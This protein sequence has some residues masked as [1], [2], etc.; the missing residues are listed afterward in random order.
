MKFTIV[1]PIYNTQ[2]YLPRLLDCLIRQT[3]KDIE[4]I[5]VDDGSTD[6]SGKICD[7][8]ALK[9]ERIKVIHKENEK[10]AE[11]RNE[12][13]RRASGDYIVF[14]DSDDYIDLNSCRVF[15]EAIIKQEEIDIL[16]SNA[17]SLNKE[18]RYKRF[19]SSEKPMS[20]CDFIKTQ[21]KAGVYNIG[22]YYFICKTS[23]L[24]GNSLYFMRNNI[25]EDFLWA[26][27]CCLLAKTMR[28]IDFAHY[29]YY[30][31]EGSISAMRDKSKHLSDFILCC[32]EIEKLLINTKD[33]ELKRIIADRNI[34]FYIRLLI[35]AECYKK[36]NSHLIRRDFF[37]NEACSGR[38]KTLNL[39]IR[40]CPRLNLFAL[41]YLV[42]FVKRV[43]VVF[44][45]ES[46]TT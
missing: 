26:T 32:Y 31:R 40:L 7:E 29:Y 3:Y 12:G 28:A 14:V 46:Y 24:K 44:S 22:P 11:A 2:E 9:D 43:K 17:I 8:Y 15:Y 16:V 30:I 34:L 23:F 13:I 20:G 4:I 5:L 33:K 21:L 27:Q 45:R 36:G 19:I 38:V 6:N 1:V 10:Q 39:M 42:P 37:R 35:Q 18:K 25:V 41:S